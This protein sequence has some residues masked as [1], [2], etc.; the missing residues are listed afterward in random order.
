MFL[1]VRHFTSKLRL[2]KVFEKYDDEEFDAAITQAV[3]DAVRKRVNAGIDDT[4]N[5]DRSR[6]AYSV[7]VTTG[8]SGYGDEFAERKLPA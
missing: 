2:A 5:D 8:L 3:R 4:K 1:R 6:L 7:G